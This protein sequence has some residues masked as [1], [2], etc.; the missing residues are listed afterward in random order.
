M[1]SRRK[2]RITGELGADLDDG[3]ERTR[4]GSAPSIRSPMMRIWALDETGKI[5]GERLHEAQE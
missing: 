2:Y 5:L 1:M 4:P 3:G